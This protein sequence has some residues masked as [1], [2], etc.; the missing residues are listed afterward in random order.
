MVLVKGREL[1]KEAEEKVYGQ[2]AFN[3]NY[4]DQ[5]DSAIEIHEILH[6]PLLLQVADPALGFFGGEYDFKNSTIE[7]KKMGAKIIA[8]YVSDKAE[9]TDIPVA[10]HLDHG[11]NFETCKACIDAG[12]T[13]VM[14]DGSSLPFEE[15]IANT[16]EVVDYAKQHNVSVEAELGVLA[17][18]EDNVVA[19]NSTYTNPLEA[20]E[21]VRRTGVDYLA[22][23][24]GT[25]HGSNKGKDINLST[26]I[27]TA[28]KQLFLFNDIDCQLVSHG[29]STVP[30]YIVKD[31]MN[32]GLDLSGSEGIKISQIKKAIKAGINKINIDTDIRM[33]TTRNILSLLKKNPELLEDE[34]YKFVANYL[35][36]NPND[37]DP[38]SSLKYFMNE[39]SQGLGEKDTELK[40]AMKDG[41]FE[42]MGQIIV[43]F[44]Q[45][46]KAN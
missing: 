15:N 25:K 43:L 30:K 5:V 42:I 44:D 40:K 16:K 45:V 37:I 3:I 18:V 39:V 6:A 35:K 22:I 14:Y 33:A 28:I 23:S 26:E 21:F 19:K 24:Y 31:L 20:L 46:G 2:A 11:R 8:D 27:V 38:R 41:A 7:Q 10:L 13:S 4:V 1:L 34:R 29:S 17:G 12:F 9:K 32:Y 36:D